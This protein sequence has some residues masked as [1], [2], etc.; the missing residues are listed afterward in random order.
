MLRNED[1]AS[2]AGLR[3]EYERQA[4]AWK[5]WTDQQLDYTLPIEDLLQRRPHLVRQEDLV[6]EVG[7]GTG[8]LSR[9]L[10]PRCGRLLTLDVVWEMARALGS[11]H[12][13]VQADVR[14][15]P[16]RSASIDV[17]A[18]LNAVPDW[19]EFARVLRPGGRVLWVS[20]FGDDTPIVVSPAEVAAGLPRTTVTWARAGHGF[21]VTAEGFR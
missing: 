14:Q 13:C 17:V 19:S 1:D 7:A 9:L 21:W 15:L 4:P 5:T 3:A 2:A 8:E 6:L 18:G 16:V 11:A 20:S 12:A 10:A